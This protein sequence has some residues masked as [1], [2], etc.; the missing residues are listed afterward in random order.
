MPTAGHRNHTLVLNKPTSSSSPASGSD[1]P[2]N[3]MSDDP[4][5]DAG[6][7][8]PQNAAAASNGGAGAASWVAKRDRSTM[9][10]IN[11]SVYDKKEEARR[12]AIEKTR[13][14]K[15]K[16]R[17]EREKAKLRNFLK[18]TNQYNVV[19]TP[20]NTG[21]KSANV[22]TYQH[23]VVINGARYKITVNGSKLV[24]VS[25]KFD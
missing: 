3:G 12:N 2:N 4:M 24:K 1:T 23:E 8:V 16:Q 25:G 13:Q 7:V 10:L 17:E 20:G 22:A 5:P 9:Q 6:S 11:T 21:A 15:I 14:D 19:D 18:G